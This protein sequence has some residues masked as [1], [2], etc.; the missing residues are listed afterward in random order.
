MAFYLLLSCLVPLGWGTDVPLS[1]SS[2]C[3]K[4]NRDKD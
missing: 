3:D 1:L 2:S 4:E